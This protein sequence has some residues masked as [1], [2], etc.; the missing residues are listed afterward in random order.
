MGYTDDDGSA[1]TA[2]MEKDR[3]GKEGETRSA[4]VV[5]GLSAERAGERSSDPRRAHSVRPPCG[6]IHP[7]AR[8]RLQ[9]RPRDRGGRRLFPH[10]CT[11]LSN[12]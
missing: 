1:A 4:L 7:P 5:V 6:G 12:I 10:T 8:R 2:A 11:A 3:G 9:P